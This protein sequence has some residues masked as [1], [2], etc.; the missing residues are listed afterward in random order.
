MRNSWARFLFAA[1][2]IATTALFLRAHTRSEVFPTRLP[3]QAFPQQLG[4]WTGTNVAIEQDVLQV[5]GPGDFLLRVYTNP[6]KAN[7]YIDMFIAYFRSQRTGDT[8]H[9]PKNCLPG[10]GWAP[11]ESS[12]VTLSVPGHAPFPANRY[13]IAKGDSRQV[14]LYWYWAH[15]RGVASEYWA[16][17]YLVADSIKMNRSDGALV[18]ITTPL[19]PGETADAAQQRLL[20]FVGDVVPQLDAYIPR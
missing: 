20:P 13:V 17:Y 5:L 1:F 15:D 11:I 14:V 8:I 3:L 19:N 9:S 2:L 6:E 10:A 7:S 16:K 18:R 12:R 4:S